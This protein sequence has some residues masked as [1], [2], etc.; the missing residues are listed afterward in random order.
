MSQEFPHN[1][2]PSAQVAYVGFVSTV[3]AGLGYGLGLLTKQ[4]FSTSPLFPL[5]VATNFAAHIAIKATTVI[6]AKRYPIANHQVSLLQAGGS[7]LVSVATLA[8]C[9]A[10]GIF[11]I[12]VALAVGGN[13]VI[14]TIKLRKAK[15]EYEN[16]LNMSCEPR[17]RSIQSYL[18]L[19]L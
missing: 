14:A 10:L 4:I 19:I 12:P 16:R 1:L 15:Y 18:S 2:T 13:L 6:L 17:D 7:F 9:A 5:V 8:T 11:G 3:A